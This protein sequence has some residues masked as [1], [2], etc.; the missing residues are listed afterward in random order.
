[1]AGGNVLA[2]PDIHDGAGLTC[3]EKFDAWRD[4]VNTAFVPLEASTVHTAAF[5]GHLISQN[6]GDIQLCEVAGSP[7]QVSR[8]TRMIAQ[9]DPNMIKLGLQLRGY[10][11]VAQDGREAALTPGDFAVYDTSRPYDLYFD[12]SFRMLVLMFPASSL[13]L[14]RDALQKVTAARISGRK[15][16]G[17][18]TS[19]LLTSMDQELN[20]GGA[21]YNFAAS[22]AL[23]GLISAT[24][25]HTIEPTTSPTANREVLF[26][27]VK[28]FILNHLTDPSLT[29]E[30]IAE[31]NNVSVRFLQRLFADHDETVSGWI[32]HQRLHQCRRELANPLL[33]GR[34]VSAVAAHWG[35]GDAANF[36]RTFK[37]AFGYTPTEF[38]YS[39]QPAGQV[40][41]L[42]ARPLATE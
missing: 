38:R 29:V 20:T 9:S 33:R 28:Q 2:L 21:P 7:L 3:S 1:M 24:I 15:G 26:E 35:F 19:A 10:C 39:Y 30:S 16:L 32:R 41:G 6:L 12:D 25:A 31:D 18:M 22:E 8:T 40:N 5:D 4:A 17:A 37:S 36:T 34:T 27:H 13:D 42:T 14:S 11:L 23:L